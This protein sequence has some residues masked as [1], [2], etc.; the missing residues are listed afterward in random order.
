M[1]PRI[2]LNAGSW[3]LKLLK[4][5]YYKP[6]IPPP[7]DFRPCHVTSILQFKM[8]SFC[9]SHFCPL[10]IP[11]K[12][13]TNVGLW[14]FGCS[15]LWLISSSSLSVCLEQAKTQLSSFTLLCLPGCV[16]GLKQANHWRHSGAGRMWR[17]GPLSSL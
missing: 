2:I 13:K 16:G 7:F 3:Q 17:Q 11:I 6:A 14:L 9:L 1:S 15:D 12:R 10:L 5:L 8:I 4:K